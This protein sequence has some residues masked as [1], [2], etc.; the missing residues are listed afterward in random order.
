MN[1]SCCS[2]AAGV[3]D[4]QTYIGDIAGQKEKEARD[5]EKFIHHKISALRRWAE[6]EME[7]GKQ[8]AERWRA[9]MDKHRDSLLN[10]DKPFVI[11]R[12]RQEPLLLVRRTR[13]SGLWNG[14]G[15]FRV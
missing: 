10:D 4:L 6:L 15:L 12:L 3:H 1:G 11:S 5:A 13:R 14:E 7:V 8:D 9:E 2:A